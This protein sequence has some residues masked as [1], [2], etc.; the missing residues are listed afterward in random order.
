MRWL[1]IAAALL[2]A[3]GANAEG[4]SEEDLLDA[5]YACKSGEN[6]D[7]EKIS[8]A[9]SKAACI[10]AIDALMVDRMAAE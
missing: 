2:F 8:E 6:H 3:A 5:V 9:E 4:L 7:G 1:L 10:K